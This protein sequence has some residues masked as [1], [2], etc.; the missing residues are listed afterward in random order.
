MID[1]TLKFLTDEINQYLLQQPNLVI[2]DMNLV[3]GNVS[4]IFD[5]D[6]SA[7]D[8]SMANKAVIS[9]VNVE[10]DRISR[11]QEAFTKSLTGVTYAQPPVLLNLYVLFVMNQRNYETATRWLSYIVR[12]F[13]HQPVFSPLSHPALNSSIKQLNVDLHTLNF[14][15]SN[16]LWS[17][18]GGKYLPSVLYKVRQISVDE[19]A[20]EAGG[21]YIRSI[22]I[23]DYGKQP[24]S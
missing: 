6:S 7:V 17:M 11:H 3:M 18:L 22:T 4:R 19:G 21:G 20:T 9:L 5:A 15:Q 2:G 13:Q 1:Q 10:E 8:I 23:N 12:F 16:Q 14:E 24:L